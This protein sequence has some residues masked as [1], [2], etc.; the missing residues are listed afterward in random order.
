[1]KLKIG[2]IVPEFKSTLENDEIISSDMLAG[3]RYVLYFYPA[4]D[5]PTCTT[6]ACNL[7]DNYMAFSDQG[8]KVFG[9]S[10]DAAKS[11]R[12]FIAK[13]DLPFSLIVDEDKKIC[14]S[15]G[16]WG[17]KTNFGRTYM[18]VIRTTFVIDEKGRIE[19]IIDN[20]KAK[21][22]HNQILLPSKYE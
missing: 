11:H 18:G 22:H 8:I 10:P 4:D 2:D 14:N 12:K 6:Q 3:S 17:E 21:D 5:T 7:R 19:N 16:V 1:M 15:F 20:V 9:V 13:Y